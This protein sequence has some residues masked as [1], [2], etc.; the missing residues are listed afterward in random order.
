MTETMKKLPAKLALEITCPECGDAIELKELKPGKM[1][2]REVKCG[3]WCESI[4]IV[5]AL[6]VKGQ[7]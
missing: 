7:A 2:E 1:E 3:E 4:L 6:W 5:P